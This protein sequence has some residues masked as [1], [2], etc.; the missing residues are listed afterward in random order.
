MFAVRS[1]GD[2]QSAWAP[3]GRGCYYRVDRLVDGGT[4]PSGDNEKPL[5]RRPFKLNQDVVSGS[6]LD[7][8]LHGFLAECLS[9]SASVLASRR[10]QKSPS[11]GKLLE[12]KPSSSNASRRAS[13]SFA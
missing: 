7:E 5:L 2:C 10:F 1:T 3:R 6:R 13:C 9:M 8:K 4:E 12:A 11:S